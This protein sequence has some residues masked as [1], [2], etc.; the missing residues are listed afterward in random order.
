MEG[1][2]HQKL[3]QRPFKLEKAELDNGYIDSSR[4]FLTLLN[5]KGNTIAFLEAFKAGC[6][7]GGMM[8]KHIFAVFLLNKAK[9]FGIIKPFDNS[10]SHSDTLLP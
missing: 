8:N 4:S 5:I 6:I 1:A 2:L 9:T 7:D 3:T 10:I